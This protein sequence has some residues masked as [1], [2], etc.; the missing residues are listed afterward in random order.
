M[1]N[2]VKNHP[3]A[4][5]LTSCPSAAPF[6]CALGPTNPWLNTIAKE[7]SDFQWEG[8][9]PSLRLLRPTFLLLN[10]PQSVT[11]LL[12]C[13][14]NTSL[15]RFSIKKSI[16]VF[17]IKLSPGNLWRTLPLSPANGQ[18]WTVSCYTLFKR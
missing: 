11:L 5:I 12:R 15:P 8:L 2:V 16:H 14:E 3:S 10:A 6:G 9:S 17:G 1:C 13:I 18:V 4:R 7:T